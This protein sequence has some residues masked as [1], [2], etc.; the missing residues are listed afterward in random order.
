MSISIS[1][2]SSV[3][4]NSMNRQRNSVVDSL[5]RVKAELQNRLKEINQSK[6]DS[7][8]KAAEIKEINQQIA[9][10]DQQIQQAKIQE[11]QEKTQEATARSAEKTAEKQEKENKESGGVVLSASL[12]QMVYVSGQISNMKTLGKVRTKL[13][14]EINLANAEIKNSVAGASNAYQMSEISDC[15]SQLAQTEQRMATTVKNTQ[16]VENAVQNGI[17]KADQEKNKIGNSDVKKT[18]DKEDRNGI[19]SDTESVQKAEDDNKTMMQKQ[20]KTV[21]IVA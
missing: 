14:G 2:N 1:S 3:D 11:Q 7:K 19:L 8:T 16:K 13:A 12:S 10:I 5:Q 17:E 18:Q 9:Q 21:D 15:T 4:N 6:E 20:Y